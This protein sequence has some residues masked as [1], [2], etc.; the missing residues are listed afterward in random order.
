[1]E[2]DSPT[3]SSI[4]SNGSEFTEATNRAFSSSLHDFSDTSGGGLTMHFTFP[5]KVLSFNDCR[6]GIFWVIK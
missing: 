3:P 6:L 1:L 2:I 5:C 4:I